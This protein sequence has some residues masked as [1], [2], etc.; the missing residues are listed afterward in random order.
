[1]LKTYI[2]PVIAG[3]INASAVMMLFEY[4]NSFLFPFPQGFDMYNHEAVQAFAAL[5]SPHIFILVFIGWC[6]GALVAGYVATHLSGEQQFRASA[7]VG[8][9]LVLAGIANHMLVGHP[10]WFNII[11]LPMLLLGTFLGHKLFL[12]K[13]KDMYKYIAFMLVV[14]LSCIAL[15]YSGSQKAAPQKA[16]DAAHPEMTFFVTSENPGAG[17]NLGGL[18]GADAY[19]TKLAKD[20]GSTKTSWRAYLSVPALNGNPAVHARDRIGKG[21][22]KNAQGELI[23][24]DIGTLHGENNLNKQTALD[25]H[26][27]AVLG[28]GEKPNE[29]DI[30][31]GSDAEGKALISETDTTCS[32]WTSATD[33]SAMVGH[34]DRVGRDESAPMKSWNAAHATRGCSIEALRSTGGAGLFYCFAAE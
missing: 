27:N 17:G 2:V 12:L 23:A 16:K 26:G 14:L 34:H 7:G 3:F 22:W 5:H 11:A 29:H 18:E 24:Q 1:M 28:K 13:G 33:G 15:L 4:I 9:L 31:T 20:A 10:L 30:L 21:P 25:Q 19:C 8:A 6:V 32:G